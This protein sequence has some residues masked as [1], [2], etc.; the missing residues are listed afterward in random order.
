MEATIQ[1]FDLLVNG[2]KKIRELWKQQQEHQRK[3][4]RDRLRIEREHTELAIETPELDNYEQNPEDEFAQQI[5]IKSMIFFREI[6]Y[7]FFS[8]I[9]I[10]NV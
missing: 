2:Q 8:L 7:I 10:V 3:A 6:N 9:I 5:I 4:D 1:F